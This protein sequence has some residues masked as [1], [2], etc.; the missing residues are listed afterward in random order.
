MELK[1]KCFIYL[2]IYLYIYLHIKFNRHVTK[3]CKSHILDNRHEIRIY[4][5]QT[6][7]A[8]SE[9][10]ANALQKCNLKEGFKCKNILKK[11][12]CFCFVFYENESGLTLITC[13]MLGVS[14]EGGRLS[15]LYFI[16]FLLLILQF[17]L[18]RAV[19]FNIFFI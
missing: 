19:K 13:I 10:Y 15:D 12:Y 18:D 7:Y 11:K 3:K 1:I 16:R 5:F 6:I 4:A 17:T 2:S 8:F 14:R 9:L